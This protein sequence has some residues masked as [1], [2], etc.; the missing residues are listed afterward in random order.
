M[1]GEYKPQ[2]EGPANVVCNLSD[3]LSK[4]HTVSVINFEKPSYPTGLG[5]WVDG[6][7]QVW[8]ERILSPRTFVF[9]QGV[10]QKMKRA[11]ILRRQT[12]LYHAHGYLDGLIGLL[13][14]SKP[15][16]LTYHGMPIQE[17][18]ASNWLKP[19]T[20]ELRIYQTIEKLVLR[21][22]DAIIV[23]NNR[24][25][26][27]MITEQ[28]VEPNKLVLIPNGVDISKFDST[29]K[30]NVLKEY[31]I[32][33]SSKK[34]IF[35]KRLTEQ[36]GVRY[37][38]ESIPNIKARYPDVVLFL[39]GE[40]PLLDELKTTA[41]RLDIGQNMRF[42][43]RVSNDLIPKYLNESD[44]FV[45]PSIPQGDAEE[46]FSISLIEAMACK[47]AVIATGIG[48][49][50]EIIGSGEERGI[51]VRPNDHGAISDAVIR[52]LDD[53]IHSKVMGENARKYIESSLTWD[54]VCDETVMVYEAVLK[55]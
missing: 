22:A 37:L 6:K 19:G 39:V 40:G 54:K 36:S 31:E 55:K 15:L 24:M 53:P 27:W 11:F 28:G 42:V 51:L 23:L 43:G 52:I 12:D 2:V 3:R 18:L 13:D 9:A 50:K 25:K 49:S 20:L 29:L 44:V 47:K 21:R 26:N 7:V 30:S 14:R 32:N 17:A 38:V 5:H 16:V 35:V 46:T 34:I 1:I 48:G 4:E 33:E 41:T 45:L 8:Q 10:V